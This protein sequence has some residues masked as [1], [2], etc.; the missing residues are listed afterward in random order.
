MSNIIVTQEQVDRF[1]KNEVWYL[2][3]FL[4]QQRVHESKFVDVAGGC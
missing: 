4:L 2:L 1:I 3:G